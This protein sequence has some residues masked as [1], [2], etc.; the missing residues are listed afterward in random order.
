MLQGQG[1]TN[2]VATVERTG[3]FQSWG[4]SDLTDGGSETG[5][6]HPLPSLLFCREG[7]TAEGIIQT[8]CV[9]KKGKIFAIV[10]CLMLTYVVVLNVIL[11]FCDLTFLCF[12]GHSICLPL[13]KSDPLQTL[14]SACAHFSCCIWKPTQLN[15]ATSGWFSNLPLG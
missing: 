3:S 10:V 6:L 5:C 15:V 14:L 8:M 7:V 4:E 13:A 2:E 11:N 12:V 9:I 1:R